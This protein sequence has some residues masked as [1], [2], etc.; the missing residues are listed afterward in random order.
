[1]MDLSVYKDVTPL[2][3]QTK[4]NK[5]KELN[6]LVDIYITIP[7]DIQSKT[8]Y[9]IYRYHDGIVNVITETPNAN[10]EK[11]EINGNSLILTVQKFSVYAI[12]YDEKMNE[13]IVE[14]KQN[15]VDIVEEINEETEVLPKTG[16][17]VDFTT[18]IMAGVL[19]TFAGVML[20]RRKRKLD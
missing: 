20:L 4:T 10:G 9:A 13:V 8:G 7:E 11:I 18:L 5:L 17:A 2:Y 19:S 15:D 16:S 3:G 12:A 6:N 1:M 14:D